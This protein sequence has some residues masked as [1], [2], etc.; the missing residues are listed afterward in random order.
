MNQNRTRVNVSR[1]VIHEENRNY[2]GRKPVD[3]L[4]LVGPLRG[5]LNSLSRVRKLGRGPGPGRHN[6]IA[7]GI[8]DSKISDAVPF[9]KLAGSRS[10]H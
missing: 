10:I 8:M 6:G 7:T 5:V 1:G 4:D 3:M 2:W 9:T